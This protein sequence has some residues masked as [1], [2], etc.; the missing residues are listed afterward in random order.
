M[1]VDEMDSDTMTG[2]ELA[3]RLRE[4]G[5]TLADLMEIEGLREEILRTLVSED[6]ETHRDIYDRLA[7]S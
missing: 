7:K 6:V 2:E 1:A 3:E 5:V 4:E